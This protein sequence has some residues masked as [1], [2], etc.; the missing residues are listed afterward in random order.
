LCAK[1][2]VRV[3]RELRVRQERIEKECPERERGG[4]IYDPMARGR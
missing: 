2:P 1:Q 3:A 4:E